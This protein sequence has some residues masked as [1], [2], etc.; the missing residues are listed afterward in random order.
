MELAIGMIT[1]P[2]HNL[3]P[4]SSISELRSGGFL[5][6]V[7]VFCEPGTPE[8][9]SDDTVVVHRNASRRGVVGNWSHCLRWLY[10]NSCAS[11]LLVV[12]DD[13]VFCG[14]ARS[15][16]EHGLAS[17]GTF[18]FLSLY[19]PKRDAG[20]VGHGIG[21]MLANRGRD[22]W[23]TQAMCF[24]RPSAEVLLG[25]SRLHVEDQL[26]GPTDSI[27]CECFLNRNIPCYYHNP[28]LADHIGR[29][30]TINHNWYPEHTGLG[31][32]RNFNGL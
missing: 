28:S 29:V 17:I 7:H 31:F 21:W 9:H 5:E 24:N 16:L 6:P 30:S 32:D 25:C 10:D 19:T 11:H 14:G 26:R 13:V 12:E 2:R 27:V 23:G 4:N 8:I 22:A 20:L 15:A 18:G 3:D 1:S